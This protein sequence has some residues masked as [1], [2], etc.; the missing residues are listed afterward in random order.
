MNPG[1]QRAASRASAANRKTG[2][3]AYAAHWQG[4]EAASMRFADAT[5]WYER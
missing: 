3:A 5:E 1:E 2:P 4:R